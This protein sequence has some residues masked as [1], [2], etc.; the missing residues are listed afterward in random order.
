M[1]HLI[2]ESFLDELKS[3]V[4]LADII[5]SH[6]V[7]LKKVGRNLA[8]LCPFHSEKS[9]SFSVNNEK[10]F[11]YCFGCGASGHAISFVS[12]YTGIPFRD[13]V[14][15]LAGQVG[16]TVPEPER[17]DA[18]S[19]AR[20][21][22]R[23]YQKKLEILMETAAQWFQD[24][25]QMPEAAFVREYVSQVRKLSNEAQAQYGVGYAPDGWDHLKLYLQKQGFSE[26]MMLDSGIITEQEG[27][28]HTYDRFRNR[29]MFPI[30]NIRGKVIAFGGRVLDDSKPKYLNSPETKLYNKSAEVYGLLE[31][32]RNTRNLSRVL[33]TEGYMD[34]AALANAGIT[35]AVASLGTAITKQQVDRMLHTS[36][37]V[38]FCFD[39]D[40]AGQNAAL[41]ALQIIASRMIDGRDF[42]FMFM[43]DGQ[44]P[45]NLV[46]RIGAE[47]FERL[48]DQSLPAVDFIQKISQNG[49]DLKRD[50]DQVAYAGRVSE[51]IQKLPQGLHKAKLLQATCHA[52]GLEAE[53]V[54][55]A[56]I[57]ADKP[58]QS[59]V[60]PQV[61]RSFQDT[62]L[63]HLEKNLCILFGLLWRNPSS[64]NLEQIRDLEKSFNRVL[65]DAKSRQPAVAR[66]YPLAQD[67]AAVSQSILNLLQPGTNPAHLSQ[68][69]LHAYWHDTPV[70][71]LAQERLRLAEE[72]LV[73]WPENP[74]KA[75]EMLDSAIQWF[76]VK[77]SRIQQQAEAS[78]PASDL[79]AR[80]AALKRMKLS[81][82]A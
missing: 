7:S 22:A 63:K 1:S 32:R 51:W 25:L 27:R 62:G 75:A 79:T 65:D 37:Q 53:K 16:M 31:A 46:Q 68:G 9:P 81:G 36:S 45:D 28:G 39:G 78:Q 55:S 10:Q 35:Y 38:V 33:V 54:I 71:E 41:K 61:D 42:R 47:A 67:V 52:T 59:T 24:Q 13:A 2:P 48:I 80:F 30:R 50:G 64:V 34:V 72:G 73:V 82:V 44:D 69:V 77:A 6:G 8:G 74:A 66:L 76:T 5:Q 23:E 70:L 49:L 58:A 4:D 17:S 57:K 19:A 11:Y 14:K 20:D 15:H 21:A 40:V 43:P 18:Q 60:L 12:E 29:I 26:K 56:G 3:R